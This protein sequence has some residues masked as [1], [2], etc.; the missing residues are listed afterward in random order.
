MRHFDAI[1]VGSGIAGLSFAY[2]LGL[3]GHRVAIITKKDRAESNTNY[4]QGG[5]A[6]VMAAGDDFEGHVKDTLAAGAGL[7]CDAVVRSIIRNGPESIQA[8]IDL[9]VPFSQLED[10]RLSLGREGGHSRRRILHVEDTTGKA[11]EKALI[12]AVTDCPQITILEHYYAIDLITTSRL[13][14][15]EN[16]RSQKDRVLGLYA[17]Q[18][19]TGRVETLRATAVLLA[20]GGI[21]QVYQYTSNP[22]I[23]TGDGIAMAY[24]AG[25][26]IRNME[27]VQFHP[28]TLYTHSGERFL[29]SEA[30]RGEGGVLRNAEGRAFMSAYHKEA[31]LAP[32]DVVARAIDQEMKQTGVPHL[33][34]DVSHCSADALR[35]R[36]PNI[37]KG[38]LEQG[39]DITRDKIPV[40]PAAHY[41]CGGIPT[42]LDGST[43]LVGLYA[44][45]EVACTGLHGAN[46]LASN[47]LLE[48]VVTARLAAKSVCAFLEENEPSSL[49]LPQWV[50]GDIHDKDERVI[51]AHNRDELKRTLWDYV[52]IV[53]TTKRLE[54]AQTR[55]RNLAAEI[56][57]YYWNVQVDVDLLELRN[58]VQTADLIVRCALQRRESRGLHY[59]LD[60][61]DQ[62]KDA[63]D[64]EVRS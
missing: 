25:L 23:A 16:K 56:D 51:L 26:P 40:V 3:A 13:S 54:R 37:Y 22:A 62:Q 44:C 42:D 41:L 31:D 30:V 39:I 17:L 21:G 7:C 2:R 47:S 19:E 34:L 45:G 5:I 20:T 43:E 10:G 36:F 18:T 55:I 46:R 59:T 64:T 12:R 58:M 61:P 49:I 38:C 27:F 1:V 33:W 32:R 28:T 50:T 63:V 11:I 48:A 53:R 52:G 60:Y 57:E 8:L 15:E 35:S 24:R 29:I 14:K 6:C 9:G 4:A